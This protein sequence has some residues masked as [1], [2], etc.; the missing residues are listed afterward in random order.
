MAG[1]RFP[2][3]LIIGAPKCGTTSLFR[4][5]GQ[6]P[7]IYLTPGKEPHFYVGD[8]RH[9]EWAVDDVDRYLARFEDAEADQ[10]CGEASTWYL[11]SR[12]AAERIQKYAPNTKC[13]ALLRHPVD[14]AYSAWSFRVQNGW[15]S[16]DFLE[17]IER[18]ETRIS[19]GRW[20]GTHYLNTGRYCEQLRRFYRHLGSGRVHV[21]W[22]EKFKGN[23][24]AVTRDVL[25]FLGVDPSI[26]LDTSSVHNSTSLP[27]SRIVNRLMKADGVREVARALFPTK[28]RTA[29][30]DVLRDF[31]EKERSA[32]D[33]ND[34]TLLT[35]RVRPSI[36]QLEDLLEV[37]LSRWLNG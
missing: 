37:D 26:E 9:P 27:R 33:P 10:L 14:R 21:L 31:N 32:L 1:S 13:I 36:E 15:E 35:E 23:P 34:R 4:Y 16:L 6:H 18:E 25:S 29:L 28:L 22:F 17:A 3:W 24:E 5:L 20:W 2:D 8:E 12:T 11:Y 7:Q 30:G 19:N